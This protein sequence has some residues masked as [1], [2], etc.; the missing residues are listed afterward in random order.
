MLQTSREQLINGLRIFGVAKTLQF[1]A[2]NLFKR[3]AGP[4]PSANGFSCFVSIHGS[5]SYAGG[6]P[7]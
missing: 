1:L 7:C 5:G 3:G 6:D 4:L 2:M